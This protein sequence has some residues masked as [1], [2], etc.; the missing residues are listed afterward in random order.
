MTDEPEHSLSDLLDG[1][2]DPEVLEL[3]R[4]GIPIYYWDDALGSV[5]EERPDGTVWRVELGPGR[6]VRY[7]DAR[8][9]YLNEKGRT[10]RPIIRF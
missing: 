7:L 2:V 4:A 9:T 3:L 8:P 5:V 10:Q 6:S 1:T